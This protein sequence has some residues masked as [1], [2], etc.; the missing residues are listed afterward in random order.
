MPSWST[1]GLWF[2]PLREALDAFVE[3]TQQNVTGT[4]T[5]SLYKGNVNI[6]E[7]RVALSLYRPIFRPSPWA[8]ATIR[9]M[10]KASSGSLVC[11]RAR[12]R[13]C[14]SKQKRGCE[15]KM[16]S[17]RF[18]EPLDADSRS[19]SGR[20]GL[21][22]SF[23]RRNCCQQGARAA[24]RG[25]G[26]SPARSASRSRV[27]CRQSA[28][29]PQQHLASDPRGRR[30]SF[31]RT[32][33]RSY[34]RN[35]R[36]SCTPAAAAMSRSRPTCGFTCASSIDDIAAWLGDFDGNAVL[37]RAEDRRRTTMPAYTHL[38][39]AEPVLVAHWLLAYVEMI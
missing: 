5:L 4:V 18:R 26:F 7:P 37:E 23:S 38:Q 22:G 8:R 3:S 12:V 2:T 39:R 11:R 30:P 13:G 33:T 24:S 29:S 19:G 35:W 17:G 6:V 28:R 34:R 36:R 27:R 31:R 20:F 1:Y 25:A 14:C 9:R 15:V 32:A 21:T 10:P 16:W